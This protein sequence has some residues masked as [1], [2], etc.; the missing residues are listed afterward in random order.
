MVTM[1]GP[2]IFLGRNMGAIFLGSAFV[3]A[4]A[5]YWKGLA[6]RRVAAY[7]RLIVTSPFLF[8]D[9]GGVGG[10][11]DVPGHLE[12]ADLVAAGVRALVAG[13]TLGGH[14]PLLPLAL[15]LPPRLL[16]RRPRKVQVRQERH[17]TLG[18]IREDFL[19]T[20]VVVRLS[21]STVAEVDNRL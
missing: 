18:I 3:S 6:D 11:A 19:S 1:G 17:P 9:G 5:I 2:H 7:A 13:D 8:I 4:Q 15:R 21:C 16:P 12:R 10:G 20:K 14:Q